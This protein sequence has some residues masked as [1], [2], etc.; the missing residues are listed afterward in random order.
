[1]SQ[2]SLGLLAVGGREL[3][4]RLRVR[5]HF[6]DGAGSH[7]RLLHRRQA[8]LRWAA[9]LARCPPLA[10]RG[11]S[12]GGRGGIGGWSCRAGEGR[13]SS[14]DAVTGA[15]PGVG[16]TISMPIEV[17]RSNRSNVAAPAS[18]S[19]TLGTSSS[20]GGAAAAAGAP[21]R[22][23][24]Q[25]RR[26]W[27]FAARGGVWL[28]G[29][30]RSCSRP[31]PAGDTS[32]ATVGLASSSGGSPTVAAGTVS[33][34]CRKSS[35]ARLLRVYWPRLFSSASLAAT[36]SGVGVGTG[37]PWRR[38]GRRRP[39]RAPRRSV[40]STTLR[41]RVGGLVVDR[42]SPAAPWPSPGSLLGAD[43]FAPRPR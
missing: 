21:A 24:M 9:R 40:P 41:I 18:L 10:S 17:P 29:S 35:V 8:A 6:V 19:S 37:V 16:C 14:P 1:M 15:D 27:L 31:W 4:G 11:R 33:A 12:G 32:G 2:A 20:V 28:P 13:R 7:G 22:P 38:G 5:G 43:V 36:C 34:L 25:P 3:R 23:P 30:S 39:R 26:A 42:S